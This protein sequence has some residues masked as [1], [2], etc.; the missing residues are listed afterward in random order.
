MGFYQN[1]IKGIG[2]RILGKRYYGIVGAGLPSN[3]NRWDGKNF[4]D[5]NEIS[6]YV[7]KAIAKRAEMVGE[8]EF[9]LRDKND[10][11]VEDNDILWLL[12]KPNKIFSSGTQFW[13]L[14]QT[15]YDLCGEVY[16][17]LEKDPT[18]RR[19][20][21]DK[22]PIS[23][24]HILYT[25]G[26]KKVYS[27]DGQL[28]H[29]EYKTNSKTVSYRPDQIIYIHRPNPKDPLNGVSLLKA[30]VNAI[31]TELQISTYHTRI[32]ENGGRVD[33]VMK[34]GTGPMTEEKMQQLKDRYEQEFAGA[35]NGNRPIF[36]GGDA[37]YERLGLN[38]TEMD[39]LN[40]KKIT[41]DDIC[42]LT[43][44]PKSMLAVTSDVKFDNA[45]ANRAIF[46]RETIK[47]LLKILTSALDE[48]LFP[49][50]DYFLTFVDPTPENQQNERE[51]IKLAS[52]VNAISTNEKREALRKL[53]LE[54]DPVD[55]GDDIL[56]PF[57]LTPLGESNRTETPPA[58]LPDEDSDEDEDKTKKKS[59]EHPLKDPAVRR[60]YEKMMIKKL[61]AKEK[62]FIKEINKYFDAQKDRMVEQLAPTKTRYFRKANADDLFNPTLE[63][64]LGYEQFLPVVYEL[65][66]DAGIDAMEMVGNR[67]TFQMTDVIN[68][69][70][71][72]QVT[73]FITQINLTTVE[74]LREVFADNA[75]AGG[76]RQDL[77]GRIETAYTG[78][79]EARAAT[80][81]RTEVHGAVQY[82][83]MRGYE[84]AGMTIKIWVAVMDGATRDSHAAIDG[85]ERPL[86]MAFS[87]GLMYPGD[88]AGSAAEVINCRCSV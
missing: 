42:L 39:F 85:E 56:I 25:P 66:K 23:S 76:D 47:P 72:H 63:L 9:Q 18:K 53:G 59:L 65:L 70:L 28:D 45:D 62:V 5:V 36:L 82:G 54:L 34:F 78:I 33:G 24:M 19:R 12:K 43:D 16:I 83:N 52:D 17:Y 31:S 10:D 27:K 86:D 40:T 57:S 3:G 77:I 79:S 51:N 22:S 80:I 81:A 50:L 74:K 41:L 61:G 67:H 20:L 84:Q 30:G 88:P 26:V 14:Y 64:R 13:A 87:N 37:S 49:E 69:W 68:S 11:L 71:D 38:P 35:K 21:T 8:I 48:A 58:D 44:V 55:S 32:L 4:L 60:V 46:L 29:Y 73:D 15:Y 7:N 75:D 1:I 2:E 6:L